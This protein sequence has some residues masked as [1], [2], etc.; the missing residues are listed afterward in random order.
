M[1]RIKSPWFE[2]IRKYNKKE[3]KDFLKLLRSGIPGDDAPIEKL[4]LL[5]NGIYDQTI[6]K[7]ALA[8]LTLFD[9][10]NAVIGIAQRMLDSW[11][12]SSISYANK[13]AGERIIKQGGLILLG[14]TLF[15]DNRFIYEKIRYIEKALERIDD[16]SCSKQIVL[17]GNSIKQIVL[18]YNSSNIM[19]D[20]QRVNDWMSTLL[21]VTNLDLRQ[22]AI[23][24]SQY[25]G[26]CEWQ[27]RVLNKCSDHDVSRAN[28]YVESRIPGLKQLYDK[29]LE[30]K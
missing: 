24:G 19:R 16:K 26:T 9:D 30:R 29:K 8:G 21:K 7:A 12:M 10:A 4:T 27:E 22:G 13:V 25:E 15:Y 23:F 18:F 5:A 28:I 1:D 14:S 20:A 17:L 11:G 3:R 6:E 2:E